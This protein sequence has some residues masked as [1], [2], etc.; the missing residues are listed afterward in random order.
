MAYTLFN[1]LTERNLVHPT[2]GL[3]YTTDLKEA[4]EMLRSCHEYLDTMGLGSMKP[5]IY[6]VDAETME[7]LVP[8]SLS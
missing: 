5:S 1:R 4:D 7:Y 3:W 6:L 8:S 2:C